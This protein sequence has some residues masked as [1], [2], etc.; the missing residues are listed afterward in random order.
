MDRSLERLLDSLLYEGYALYPYTPGATKNATPTPFG[1]VYPPAYAERNDATYDLLRMECVVEAAGDA[2]LHGEVRFLQAEGERHK[3]IE[4]RV[5]IPA[6]GVADLEAEGAGQEFGFDAAVRLEGRVR[7]RATTLG[8]GLTRIV[9][10]VHNTTPVE[11]DRVIDRTRALSASL[12]ST[13]TVAEIAGG[14]FI[15]PLEREG[16]TGEAVATCRNVNTW[17]VLASPRDDAVLGAA[18]HLPDHPSMAPES[19][20]N[21]FDSTEIEEALLLHVHALSDDERGAIAEQDPAV[22]EMVERALGAGREDIFSLHGRLEEVVDEPGHPVPGE[23]EIEVDGVTFRKGGKVIL[24][25]GR[26][27]DVYDSMLDGRAATIERLYYDSDGDAHIAVTV[28]GDAAQGLFRETGRYLFFRGHEVEV[29][30]ER[31][32]TTDG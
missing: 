10:C 19:L 1:I 14:R 23:S 22:R 8:G 30:P 3:G 29:V 16:V 5:E 25:P 28:D 9:V 20:G 17:P 32:K 11:G 15:S 4:R 13:H 27:R 24:R 7:M 12:I 2:V 26:S 21:L 18:I 6:T 31:S